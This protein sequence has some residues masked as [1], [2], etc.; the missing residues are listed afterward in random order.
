MEDPSRSRLKIFIVKTLLFLRNATVPKTYLI[1][2]GSLLRNAT[3]P[4]TC[5]PLTIPFLI[6]YGF[7]K[8]YLSNNFETRRCCN[9]ALFADS[10]TH[11]L[12]AFVNK[13]FQ[14]WVAFF[15]TI[16]HWNVHGG[17]P[18]LKIFHAAV[19]PAIHYCEMFTTVR[20]L[21]S[22]I[23]DDVNLPQNCAFLPTPTNA[24][25]YVFSVWYAIYFKP[26]S[27]QVYNG[28]DIMVYLVTWSSTSC[29]I[30][31]RDGNS[32]WMPW[33]IAPGFLVMLSNM[34]CSGSQGIVWQSW[35]SWNNCVILFCLTIFSIRPQHLAWSYLFWTTSNLSW[36]S[37]R[38]LNFNG[39]FHHT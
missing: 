2:K 17:L 28:C 32:I 21:C 24:Q 3:V 29:K 37:S 22:Q 4:K 34:R 27:K 30:S 9:S 7:S 11:R 35:W 16:K 6:S 33:T 15:T 31:P 20:T 26:Y 25:L 1:G 19:M 14:N 10:S 12:I 8:T 18:N 38:N 39:L 13:G 23:L 36:L 5:L